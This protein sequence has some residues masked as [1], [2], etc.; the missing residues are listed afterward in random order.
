MANFPK[1][2]QIE[3]LTRL[4]VILTHVTVQEYNLTEYKT[5]YTQN[6]ATQFFPNI[7]IKFNKCVFF[8]YSYIVRKI[9]IMS[10]EGV[11]RFKW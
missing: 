9:Y 5:I 2:N 1:K 10:I 3:D 11:I 6:K 7:I 8:I 4:T